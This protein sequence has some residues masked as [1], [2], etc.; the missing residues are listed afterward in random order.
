[1]DRE[2]PEQLI[3]QR[4]IKRIAVIVIVAASLVLSVLALR[5]MI[6]PT[7]QR[8]KIRTAIAEIGRIDAAVTASGVVVPEFEQTLTTPVGSTVE[9]ILKRN[10]DAVVAG[11][12]IL[13]LNTESLDLELARL[14]SELELQKNRKHQ[15][16]LDIERKSI[17]LQ[18]QYDIK[19]LETEF[20]LSQYNRTKHLH[21]LGGTTGEELDRAALNLDIARREFAQ[22][23][24][25]IEN[26]RAALE[27][28]LDGL[29][30]EIIIRENHLA[31]LRRQRDLADVKASRPG[32]VTWVNDKVGASVT[33]GE[34]VARVAD[35]GSFKIE[36]RISD[37]H[38][39]KLRAGG[40]V[41]VRFGNRDLTGQISSVNPAV[42]SGTMSFEVELADSADPVLRPNL[43]A[44][45]YV[46]T[47]YVDSVLR[48]A[49]GPFHSRPVDQEVFVIDGNRAIRR[50]VDIGISNY[51][52][53]ELKGD[54]T[55]GDEIII[56]DMSKYTHM[57][58]VNLSDE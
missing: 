1:M 32:I 2:L 17:D 16:T 30:L 9:R 18:A 5:A 54:I 58:A 46:I 53:V 25:Q 36:G 26:Q 8:S 47:E 45:V 23:A 55:P 34:V 21:D 52:F 4:R 50:V 27:T 38:A 49:N 29:D 10:G 20:V 31:N 6:A 12:S 13:G 39:E 15:L 33:A 48:V 3:R 57:S 22:A 19:E 28:E 7:L 35:L 24:K 51:D 42:T 11:E 37:I 14:G 56:S 43:R 40:P 41:R 44:D